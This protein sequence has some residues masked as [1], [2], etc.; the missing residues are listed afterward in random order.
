MPR[1]AHAIRSFNAG[2]LSPRMEGRTD[3]PHYA[4]AASRLENFLPLV[5]GPLI[6]RSGTRFVKEVRNSAENTVLIPFV[7][8]TQ[9]AYVI[10]AGPLYF[11]FYTEEARL[12]SGGFPVEL[13][14]TY[15]A[16]DL[17]RI[18]WAQ[19]A[20]TLYLVHPSYPPRK[21]VRTSPTSFAIADV[22]FQDGPYL[23]ENA[24]TAKTLTA[25]AGTGAITITAVGHTPFV[26]GR[27]E[28]RHIRIRNATAVGWAEVTSV[29]STTVVNATVR[30]FGAIPVGAQRAWRLG[31]WTVGSFPRA[32]TFHEQRLWFVGST[33]AIQ[34]FDGSVIGDFERFSPTGA[35]DDATAPYSLDS[36]NDDNGVGYTIGSNELNAIL[37]ARVHRVLVLGTSQS[38]FTVAASTQE[39]AI[40]PT[41]VNVHEE[42]ITGASEVQPVRLANTILF[43]GKSGQSIHA[44]GYEV[45]EDSTIASDVTE[46]ADHVTR[47]SVVQLAA[48]R[49][50]VPVL[51]MINDVGELCSL[52]YQPRQRVFGWSRHPVGGSTLGSS[53]GVVRSIAVLPIEDQDQLW[54][55]VERRINGVT[56]R[57]VEFLEDLF[58]VVVPGQ[59]LEDAFFVDSGVSYNAPVAISGA[60]QANPVVL[61]AVGH[62]FSNGD[63]VR[64]TKIVGMT[65]L[66][67]RSF[68]IAN[69]SANAFELV[70]ENGTAHTAYA[71]GGEVRLKQTV[72]AGL[73]HLEG[74]TVQVL[75]DGA[76]APEAVVS[77]GSI[78]LAESASHVHVGFGRTAIYQSTRVE[79][80]DPEGSSLG[81]SR[82]VDTVI[83]RLLD[84]LGGMLG[85]STAALVEIPYRTP[86]DEMDAAPPLFTGEKRISFPGGW[87]SEPRL[88]VQQAQP[89]PM[90][91]LAASL[92]GEGAPR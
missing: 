27:D 37:W 19:S 3:L 12:E 22:D 42:D 34:R 8:S 84:S 86:R 85:A 33:D 71:S 87:S 61:T 52:T 38:L 23:D 70:G 79:T 39:E 16:A 28:G 76:A 80:G 83:L 13:V 57:Y 62:G 69:I 21:L 25:S 66:N 53:N 1:F 51:W 7:V 59:M 5:Q 91:I 77:A 32:V 26:V 55:I 92:L 73:G 58:R 11:R 72:F 49:E 29:T 2:E 56:R 6:H 67:G 47:Q 68:T 89:L 63:E 40:T 90:T 46:L 64:V 82:Q 44:A 78:T 4:A 31:V 14:T 18:Q 30:S 45:T 10:E 60:T 15:A 81:K 43:V 75:A 36:I 54:L 65:Q 35:V 41:N 24:D 20:D 17:A 50:P 48:W 88:V 74:A 9:A